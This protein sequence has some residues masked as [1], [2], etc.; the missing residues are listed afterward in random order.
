MIITPDNRE[1]Q[2]GIDLTSFIAITV[3]YVEDK[4]GNPYRQ[5]VAYCKDVG[6][7]VL[8]IDTAEKITECYDFLIE[9]LNKPA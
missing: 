7:V 6:E 3:L 2:F 9:L 5:L 1:H 8:K 4:A